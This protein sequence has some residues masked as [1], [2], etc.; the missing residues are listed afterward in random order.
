[1]LSTSR[2]V[3]VNDPDFSERIRRMVIDEQ[4]DSEHN[5]SESDFV[6]DSDADL[7]YEP[8]VEEQTEDHIVPDV[9]NSDASENKDNLLQGEAILREITEDNIVY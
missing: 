8:S 6:D 1:M 4:S 5:S 3:D 2:G 9:S 7:N